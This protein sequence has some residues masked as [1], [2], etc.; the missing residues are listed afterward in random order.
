MMRKPRREIFLVLLLAGSLGM[1]P[2]WADPPGSKGNGN[3]HAGGS[4]GGGKG[5]GGQGGKG[6]GQ[7]DKAPG[8]GGGSGQGRRSGG[9]DDLVRAGITVS[10]ARDYASDYRAVGY[11]PLPPGIR[12][13]LA[14]GKPLPPGIAKK[15]VPSDMLARLPVYPGY[16]WRVAGT[17]LILVSLATLVVADVLADVFR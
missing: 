13:N 2:A 1:T 4:H 11:G 3:A 9:G 7:G 8:K 6:H 15:A 16:E 5:Q 10:L 17:D 12:K 14:R